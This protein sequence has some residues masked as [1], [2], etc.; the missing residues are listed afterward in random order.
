MLTRDG[1][2]LA[3]ELKSACGQLTREQAG[4]LTALGAVAGIVVA[5]IRPADLP[6]VLAVLAGNKP[7][8][9]LDAL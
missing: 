2:C 3:L 7:P 4:W 6:A 9:S 8:E 1:A 5:V